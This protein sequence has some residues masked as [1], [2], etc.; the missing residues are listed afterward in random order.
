MVYKFLNEYLAKL[1]AL[2]SSNPADISQSDFIDIA[3]TYH[4]SVDIKTG[5]RSIF[6][7]QSSN[8]SVA[9]SVF[10]FND[11]EKIEK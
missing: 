10:D 7:P 3:N 5:G 2:T 4:A 8:R 11:K 1:T 9:S 6:T